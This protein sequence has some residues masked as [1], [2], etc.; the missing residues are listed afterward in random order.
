M[1]KETFL[2][3]NISTFFLILLPGFFGYF[4]WRSVDTFAAFPLFMEDA[5]KSEKE[6][7]IQKLKH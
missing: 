6:F 4:A 1:K 3:L 2:I 5:V 7:T